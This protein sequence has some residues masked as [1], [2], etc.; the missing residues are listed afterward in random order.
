MAK[1]EDLREDIKSDI[2][3]SSFDDDLIDRLINQAVRKISSLVLLPVLEASD[4]SDTA[5]GSP[6]IDLPDGFG[7][8]LFHASTAR[9][10]VKVLSSMSLLLEEYPMFAAE[11]ATGP[12]EFCCLLATQIAIHPVPAEITAVHLFYHEWPATLSGTG[13][14]SVYIPDE[15]AQEAMVKHYVLGKLHKKLEDG[16]E[17]AMQNTAYHEKGF[18]EAVRAYGLTIKQG[19]S[20]PSPQRKTW[21]I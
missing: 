18:L 3:D 2:D 1:V 15:E 17:G 7:H 4:T 6:Y 8:N 20:R 16:L 19:Q 13:D 10:K 21:G 11:N 12:V 14:L 5:V 9:G